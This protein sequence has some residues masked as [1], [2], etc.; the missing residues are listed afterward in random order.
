[1]ICVVSDDILK[2]LF[3]SGGDNPGPLIA[4]AFLVYIGILK[5]SECI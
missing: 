1:M 3:E 5:V 2:Q 4:N